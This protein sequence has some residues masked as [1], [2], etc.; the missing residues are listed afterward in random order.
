[1][2]QGKLSALLP[3][4]VFLVVFVGVGILTGDFYKMPAVVGFLIALVVALFQNRKI[5]LE[6]KIRIVC[7]GA[8]EETILT[9]VFIF[10][11]AG[12]FSGVINAAGGV[13]STV[14]FSLSIIP[15]NLSVVGI[16]VVGCF[17]SLSMGTSVGTITALAPI[18][19]GI[20]EKTG[21]PVSLCVG[22]VVCG[23]MFGDNLSMISDTTIAAVRTQGCQMKDK[24]KQNFLIV[25][26]AAVITLLVLFWRTTDTTY[27]VSGDLDYNLLQIVPYLIVLVGAL[28]GLHVFVV[29]FSGIIASAVVGLFTQQFTVVEM[30]GAMGKGIE[31]MYEISILSIIVAAVVALV[32]H[33]GGIQ[34]IISLVQRHVKSRRGAELGITGV[35][36]AVDACTANNTI[37]IVMAG[38]I[39][40]EIGDEYEIPPKTVA[41]LLDISTS[42]AQGLLPYGAQLLTAASLT[43]TTPVDILPNLYYPILMAVSALCFILFWRKKSYGKEA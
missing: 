43:G 6:E 7:K 35:A 36:L 17:I 31:S 40:K 8:G 37:A 29:L 5:K 30:F 1:M 27:Q 34:Y 2:N 21:L 11:L 14:N 38:G 26:P 20:S 4:A 16:F 15:P 9:M 41:S 13:D 19:L 23:A 18:A 24:F 42:V 25:L 22:A 28:I 33:N 32:R 3:I 12:A 10:I 39:V